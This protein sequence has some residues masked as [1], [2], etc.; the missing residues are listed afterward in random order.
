MSDDGSDTWYEITSRTI[1]WQGREAVQCSL[2]DISARKEVEQLKSEFVSIV[3]HELR[4]PLTSV[5]G[6]LGLIQ[7]GALGALPDKV[8]PLIKI[9]HS[10]TQ[11]LVSLVN[12][13][14]DVEKIEAGHMD[15]HMAPVDATELCAQALAE[16][17][18]YGAKFGVTFE[19]QPEVSEAYV[20]ADA[21]RLLQLLAN[22]LSN[23]A[24]FSPEGGRVVLKLSDHDDAIRFSIIDEGAGIPAA[25]LDT[26]FEKF[27]QADS[28]DS[29]A[30]AGTGLGLAICQSIAEHHGS[31]IAVSSVQGEGSTFYFD[32]KRTAAPAGDAV[33]NDAHAC[34][35]VAL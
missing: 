13:I 7:S 15:F 8:E 20:S 34:R 11:R 1:T 28:S 19:L 5:T 4:T 22:L 6:S 30:K 18:F 33:S 21:D 3:S 9:A 17:V 23:A 2:T 35:A 16:N 29:R 26:I 27:K 12:D 31:R 14:L 25:K 32:L 10:N 24:K